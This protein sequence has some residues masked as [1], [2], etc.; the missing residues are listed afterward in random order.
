M[1]EYGTFVF[2][3]IFPEYNSKEH[4]NGIKKYETKKWRM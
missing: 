3:N 1:K 4:M 2:E